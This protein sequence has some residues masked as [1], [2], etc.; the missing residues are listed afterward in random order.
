MRPMSPSL[1]LSAIILVTVFGI[2]MLRDTVRSVKGIIKV[3]DFEVFYHIGEVAA[4][5]QPVIYDVASPV[6]QRGP[7]LY[8]PSAAVLFVPLS[9]LSHNA[10]GTVFGIVKMACLLLL[11][12]GSVHW[13]GARPRDWVGTLTAM[14]IPMVV[15]HRAIDS[16]VGNGQVNIVIAAAAVGGVWLMMLNQ[17]VWLGTGGALLAWAIAI[18][19]TPALLLAVPLM[20][21]R[22]KEFGFSVLMAA[23]LL[24]ALP[25][26]WFGTDNFKELLKRHGEIASRFSMDWP[27]LNRQIT[28]NEMAQFTRV[29]HRGDMKPN[30]IA[31]DDP[32]KSPVMS[33]V[34]EGQPVITGKSGANLL[35]PELRRLTVRLWIAMGLAVGALY[36]LMRWLVFRGGTPDW[37]WDLTMMCALIVLL[38]PRAHKAHLAILIVPAGWIAARIFR[39]IESGGLAAAWKSHAGAM[40][41]VLLTCLLFLISEN[42]PVPI[43]GFGG[44][45]QPYRCLGFFAL[46]LMIGLVVRLANEPGSESHRKPFLKQP[47]PV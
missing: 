13:S 2:Y 1:R 17:R 7:F 18:K 19:L 44:L 26:L 20:N 36:F 42:V 33:V 47:S 40:I 6:K 21:R 31:P 32:D 45:E 12:W 4:T 22:W 9:W 41:A 29:V 11:Y 23:L 25:A 38:S 10:A 14:V 5:R 35:N 28:L 16:D 24:F 43:P 27:A 8:P 3:N 15:A 46:L 39:W 30:E 37:T 34:P